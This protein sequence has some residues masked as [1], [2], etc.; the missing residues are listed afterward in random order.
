MLFITYLDHSS[1]SLGYSYTSSRH[2]LLTS[3][4]RIMM[5]V[6]QKSAQHPEQIDDV[7]YLFIMILLEMVTIVYNFTFSCRLLLFL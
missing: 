2:Y 4:L 7:V 6:L 3:S 5:R 1:F